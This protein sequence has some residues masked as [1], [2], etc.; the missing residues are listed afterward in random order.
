M[1]AGFQY[2]F[3]WNQQLGGC[4]RR[5]ESKQRYTLCVCRFTI[6]AS[7]LGTRRTDQRQDGEPKRK[8]KLSGLGS[9]PR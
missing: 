7:F 2:G 5:H 4:D 3:A 1:Q 6:R 9:S 8:L